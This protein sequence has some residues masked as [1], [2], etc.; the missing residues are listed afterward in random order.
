[1]GGG[2]DGTGVK[3]HEERTCDEGEAEE[4]VDRIDDGDAIDVAV[5]IAQHNLFSV[6]TL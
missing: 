5:G 1:M 4:D 6:S 2:D 3:A